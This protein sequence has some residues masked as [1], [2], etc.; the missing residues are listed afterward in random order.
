MI[1]RPEPA[2]ETFAGVAVSASGGRAAPAPA[3]AGTSTSAAR[4]RP[5][6]RLID[7]SP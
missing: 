7:R 2:I 1:A 4:R 6:A 5:A 3:E